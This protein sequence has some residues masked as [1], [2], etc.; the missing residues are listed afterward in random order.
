M[1]QLSGQRAWSTNAV[2]GDDERCSRRG[3]VSG[4]QGRPRGTN[5]VQDDGGH[6]GLGGAR[7]G[8][9]RTMS[10]R[11][12]RRRAIGWHDL[13]CAVVREKG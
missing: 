7:A 4:A 11:V 6:L 2:R 13:A 8:L 1:L 9:G 10:G 3:N 12:E 5:T